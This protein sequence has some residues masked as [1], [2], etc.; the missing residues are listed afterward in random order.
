MRLYRWTFLVALTLISDAHAAAPEVA[1]QDTVQDWQITGALTT[2]WDSYAVSGDAEV[3]PYSKTGTQYYS[4]LAAGFAR[5]ISSYEKISAQITAA[6][7]ESA[8]RGNER[9][10]IVQ[11]LKAEW[12][13][14][15]AAIP[16]RAEAGDIFAFQSLRTL[17]RGLRGAQVEWQPETSWGKRQ[18]V[19]L[20]GG[21]TAASYRKSDTPNDRFASVGWLIEET[22]LGTFNLSNTW[23][24]RRGDA[25]AVGYSQSVTSLGFLQTFNQSW[26][27][28]SIQG[29][30]ALF[31]GSNDA[32]GQG[33]GEVHDQA[34]SLSL[35][36]RV[37]NL[38][39]NYLMRWERYGQ[40]YRPSGAAAPADTDQT[41]LQASWRFITGQNW[42]VRFLQARDGWDSNREI[43]TRTAQTT[44]SGPM[45]DR[46]YLNLDFASQHRDGKPTAL[47][48]PTRDRIDN[49][50]AEFTYSFPDS[51]WGGS[52]IRTGF[53]GRRAA[54]EVANTVSYSRD[55][56]LLAGVPFELG[57]FRGMV[58]PGVTWRDQTDTTGTQKSFSPT[59]LL[60]ASRD[61]HSF[62]VSRATTRLMLTDAITDASGKQTAF[63]YSYN[64]R[65]FRLTIDG[66]HIDRVS[67]FDQRASARRIGFSI[68]IPFDRPPGG[69]A[70]GG[71]D[72]GIA[73]GAG[74]F[75]GTS[76]NLRAL[77]PGTELASLDALTAQF[78][79]AGFSTQGNYRVSES[80]VFN[81]VT[82]RQR[83]V[84]RTVND[85]VEV[86]AIVIDTD[87]GASSADVQ[88]QYERIQ[89]SMLR[90]YG[91]PSVNSEQGSFSPQLVN[92]LN[93]GVFRRVMEW[94]TDSGMLRLGIPRR[95]D[96]QLRF[97][98]QLAPQF[99]SSVEV[100]RWSLEDFR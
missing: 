47:E 80:Q 55:L 90:A 94:R 97:E 100:N 77:A 82:L 28:V 98:I 32:Q 20:T 66:E 96:G 56:F 9:G 79:M 50:R 8:Y 46:V 15:D 91:S 2:R 30:R 11:R 81:Q 36:G 45:I 17:Q 34:S 4:D 52:N 95:L 7:N 71:N 88:R 63:S 18:S 83:V 37:I 89:E 29:E 75:A 44:F 39:L 92:D 19:L 86:V 23:G 58:S 12:E 60:S 35:D 70:A 93:S 16:F 33:Q 13:K 69:N 87:P 68:T 84:V 59:L 42:V 22:P 73:A 67:P 76:F 10:G 85:R 53:S 40:G 5:R 48:Q 99:N 64:A 1:I 25:N 3:A 54:S 65:Q 61:Q 49:G 27:R 74:V 62:T 43:R 72:A 38:P 14:G 26:Q 6:I 31:R 51:F 57:G 41:T 78:R 21:T 24:N